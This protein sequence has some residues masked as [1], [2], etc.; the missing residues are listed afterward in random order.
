MDLYRAFLFAS[1]VAELLHKITKETSQMEET[2]ETV[3]ADTATQT[4]NETAEP[5]K[6]ETKQENTAQS[7]AEKAFTQEELDAVVKHRIDKQNAK[8]A[9]ELD[10]LK[11]RIATLEEEGAKIKTERDN[12]QHASDISAWKAKAAQEMGVQASILRGDSEEEIRQ[13]AQAIKDAMPSVVVRDSGAPTGTPVI[14]RE[15]IMKIKD[16]KER[17]EAINEHTELFVNKQQGE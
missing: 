11:A 15:S 13:H 10:D 4:A 7:Q 8:H 16:G 12:L 5:T 1:V 3:A 14:T 9:K 17:L 6:E 2:T